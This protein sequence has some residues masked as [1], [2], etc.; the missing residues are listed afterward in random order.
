MPGALKVIRRAAR[1]TLDAGTVL[2]GLGEYYIRGDISPRVRWALLHLHCRT[3]GKFTNLLSPLMR[4][5]R[6]PRKAAAAAGVLG[7]L[8]V[9]RQ[10]A[11]DDAITR[12]GFFVF[13]NLLPEAL[14]D[15]ID[16]F[17]RKTP[18]LIEGDDKLTVF[19]P[20]RP[21]SKTY[22]ILEPDVVKCRAMQELMADRSILAVA[23]AYLKTHPILSGTSL[24]YSPAYGNAPGNDA[25]Q[26]FH[27][28]FD[29]PP[30]WLL[31][32]IYL[33]D[34]GPDN[35]PHIFVRGT[36]TPSRPETADLL[37]RGYVRIPDE[38]IVERFGADSIVELHGKRGTVLAVDTRGF[39]K[40]KMPV[41]GHRLMAQLS[42]SC[43]PFSGAHCR[44]VPLPETVDPALETALAETPKVFNNHYRR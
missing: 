17:A 10:K 37:A 14:C 34:V 33:T 35:G 39:H 24:W 42:F 44:T 32:F 19:N 43:P 25:A 38:D 31:F 20:E 26:E 36:H 15:E 2:A 21:V 13:E 40:G 6:P 30:I 18:A 7:A 4:A 41:I 29:P 28:D 9:A 16:A 12:D 27:F 8:S 22:R 23:E 5:A 3:N 1:N 11:I